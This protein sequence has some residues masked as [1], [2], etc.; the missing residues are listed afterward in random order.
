MLSAAA[1]GFVTGLTLIVAIGA[2][3]AYVL[4]LG[5]RAGRRTLAPV[6]AL[7]AGSDAV[8]I[9]A[10]TLGLGA[11]IEREPGFV[12]VV[13]VVGAAFLICYGLLA[14]RRAW[15]PS[16]EGLDAEGAASV[17][18]PA[19]ALATAA[20][21]TWLNPHV[22]LDTVVFLGSVASHQGPAL[23]W[24]VVGGAATA[25]AVW[26]TGVGFGA[27]ALRPLFARPGAWRVLDAVIAVVILGLG[28]GLALG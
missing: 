25:S 27:R 7:C 10:G 17:P 15:R 1:L 4:R 8:L 2:Q 9:A 11:L 5:L 28:V 21:F 24:W 3:N 20:A 6:V 16:G 18:H 22:Y 13:R 12:G 26:F 19:R 23:Q 14:A